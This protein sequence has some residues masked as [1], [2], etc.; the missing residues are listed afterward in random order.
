[1][2]K[3]NLF[4]QWSAGIAF[5]AAV[6]GVGFLAQPSWSADKLTVKYGPF[7]RSLLVSDLQQYAETGKASPEL[8]SFLNLVKGKQKDS[9]RKALNLK[10]PFDV[11]TVD[12]LLKSPFADQ[13]LTKVADVTILPGHFE[14]EALRSALIVSAASKEGLG[15]MGILKNYPTQTLTVDLKKMLKLLKDSKGGIPGLEGMGGS[16][17][18]PGGTS[19][20]EPAPST[21]PQ[22]NN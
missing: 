17:G 11:V 8:S 21:P 19:T 12:K 3:L 7:Y 16:M 10:M 9:L 20:P 6:I 13:L 22:K 5:G 4:R 1:M 18:L 2:I 14:K 15:T